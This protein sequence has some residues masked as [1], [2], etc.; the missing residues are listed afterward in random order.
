MNI[1]HAG[2]NVAPE[3]KLVTAFV[4]LNSAQFARPIVHVLKQVAVNG[5]EMSKIECPDGCAFRD[6]VGH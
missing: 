5:T 4:D 1:V 6:S 2:L 3:L